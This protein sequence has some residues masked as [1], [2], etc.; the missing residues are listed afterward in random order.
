MSKVHST[1]RGNG[2]C[3]LSDRGRLLCKHAFSS[4][5]D[6]YLFHN[7]FRLHFVI[8]NRA[9]VVIVISLGLYDY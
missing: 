4:N 6:S 5:S 9:Y 3:A 7:F 2:N 1:E 8:V